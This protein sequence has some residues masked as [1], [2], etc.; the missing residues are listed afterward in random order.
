MTSE[1]LST[2][3]WI[4]AS[5]FLAFYFMTL[6]LSF[7]LLSSFSIM[8]KK[9]ARL[10]ALHQTSG[11][12]GLLTIMFH[13]LLILQDKY[14]PYSLIELLLPLAAKNKPLFSALGTLSFY[15]FLLV[16]VTSD[17]WIKKLGIKLWRKIHLT[18]IPAWMLM[19]VHGVV[20]GTDS[21]EPWAI[22][23]Y[24]SSCSLISVLG[25]IRYLETS[26]Q[27]KELSQKIH[28]VKKI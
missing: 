25:L 2:W 21:R 17:F 26:Y 8:K 16:I 15:L 3:I 9:K 13:M 6:S 4:R 7:G 12:M 22:F 28:P 27:H 1:Y 23:L 24:A 11:W 10:I 18:V 20:I 5:G 19:L 14:A